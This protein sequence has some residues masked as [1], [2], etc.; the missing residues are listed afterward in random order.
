[1]ELLPLQLELLVLLPKFAGV[2]ADEEAAAEPAAAFDGGGGGG[3]D[4]FGAQFAVPGTLVAEMTG[5]VH[6]EVPEE[7]EVEEVALELLEAS[8]D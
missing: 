1:M 8:S 2:A 5:R 6:G 3:G 7:A 4:G